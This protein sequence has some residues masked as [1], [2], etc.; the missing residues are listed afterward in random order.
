[1][2]DQQGGIGLTGQLVHAAGHDAQG[3][4][5]QAGIGLIENR[6][7]RFEQRHLQNLVALLLAT[8]E[9]LVHRAI[10]EGRIH[11]HQLHPLAHQILK[12]E[13]VQLLLAPLAAAGIGSHPQK[14]QIAHSGNLHRILKTKKQA[15][16]G[17]DFRIQL[18]QVFTAIGNRTTGHLIGG[19]AR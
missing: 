16:A 13:G 15:T 19:M 18:Q 2:G 3:V 17:P 14:L 5:I 1:M 6:H 10:Q 7:Q 12:G 9:A 8:T 4:D 11:L